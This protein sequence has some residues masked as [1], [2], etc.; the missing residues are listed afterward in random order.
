MGRTTL[1]AIAA[2]LLSLL[3]ALPALT[4]KA[5]GFLLFYVAGLPIYMAGLALGA[6]A[7]SIASLSG[8]LMATAMGGM[9]LSGVYALIHLLP[10]WT[11]VRQAMLQRAA[12]DGTTSWYPP[13]PILAS[14]SGLAAAMVG[15]AGLAM[16][17]E[18]TGMSEVISAKLTEVLAALVPNVPEQARAEMVRAYGP[19]LPASAGSSWIVMAV[20]SATVAQGLVTRLGKN[21]RPTP[22]YSSMT[23]PDWLSWAL[24]GSALVALVA[25]GEF[26]YIARNLTLILAV[27]F[28]LLGLAV[29]HTWVKSRSFAGMTLIAVYLFLFIAGWA[30][31]MAAAGLGVIEQWAGLRHRFASQTNDAADGSDDGPDGS[32]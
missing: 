3:A 11:V 29:V 10:A 7:G 26:Q 16:M 15:V 5:G 18:G 27:P 8:F 20:V 30:G 28:F 19:F 13:G 21:L 6:T 12:P 9:L 2:G 25:P 32:A 17:A 14:L 24:V 23:L 4:G 31:L 22:S 1:I